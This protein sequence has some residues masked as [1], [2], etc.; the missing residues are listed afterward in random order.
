[1]FRL[2]RENTANDFVLFIIIFIFFFLLLLLTIRR[3][4]LDLLF[5][6]LFPFLRRSLRVLRPRIRGNDK[7]DRDG[8]RSR[9]LAAT[10]S[11]IVVENVAAAIANGADDADDDATATSD[12]KDSQPTRRLHLG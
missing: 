2:E 10:H 4:L 6:F 7:S 9:P 11:A 8:S 5:L 1:M 3:V 12:Y